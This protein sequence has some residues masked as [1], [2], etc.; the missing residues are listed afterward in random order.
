MACSKIHIDVCARSCDFSGLPTPSFSLLDRNP[1]VYE[2]PARLPYSS[3]GPVGIDSIGSLS[4]Y[5]QHYDDDG[6]KT[7]YALT[8]RHV[9][10][11]N[12]SFD[13]KPSVAGTIK[14]QVIS[15]A[16][17][18]HANSQVTIADVIAELKFTSIG[19]TVSKNEIYGLEQTLE[20]AKLYNTELGY[21][22]TT[23]GSGR[24]L[25]QSQSRSDWATISITNPAIPAENKVCE[26]LVKVSKLS[27]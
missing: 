13:N 6:R 7:I 1:E 12:C 19:T 11:P 25:P 10:D 4:G 15:P 23:S 17:A 9:V 26:L 24:L 21:V 18:D 3:I 2:S 16:A 5:V 20:K 8:C 22:H 14:R 27:C